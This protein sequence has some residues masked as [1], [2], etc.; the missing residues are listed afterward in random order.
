MTQ[1]IRT[2]VSGLSFAE[3]P[4]WHDGALYITDMFDNRVLRIDE[5]GTASVVARFD[6]PVSG[7]GWL[8][9][10]RMLAVSMEARQVLRQEEDSRFVLHADLSGI[11]TFHANDM[12]VTEDGTAYVGNFG[13]SL[14]PPA[15]PRMAT[16]AKISPSGT[17]TAVAEDLFFPNGMAVTPD[18]GTLIVAETGGCRIVAFN[19]GSDGALAG[20]R[21]WADLGAGVMP[22]GMCLDEEGAVWVALPL[23]KEFVRVREGGEVVDRIQVADAALACVLGG[24][25]RRTLYLMTSGALDPESCRTQRNASVLAVGV[26][27]PGAGRP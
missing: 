27:I 15:E 24:P 8:P 5:G 7:L 14:H 11:A 26:E 13:F 12:I 6:A 17:T 16:L 2:I 18:N 23:A 21:I 25:D 4:R 10:G 20:R 19:I 9:D 3:A 1:E 22:D